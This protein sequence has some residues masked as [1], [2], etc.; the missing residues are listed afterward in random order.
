MIYTVCF[1]H[2]RSPIWA[3]CPLRRGGTGLSFCFWVVRPAAQRTPEQR[4]ALNE[5]LRPRAKIE[6]KIAELLRR[7]GLRH[8][9][10]LGRARTQLQAAMT[11][12]VVNAK[13]LLALAAADEETAAALRAA[14]VAGAGALAVRLST[15]WRVGAGRLTA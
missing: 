8:G 4:H 6:R 9:R 1:S 5:R 2:N 10:Y 15:L 7:H 13:R 14:F 11:A 3:R 12:A